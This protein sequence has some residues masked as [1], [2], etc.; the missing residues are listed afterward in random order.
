VA[1]SQGGFIGEDGNDLLLVSGFEGGWLQVTTLVYALDTTKTPFNWE[2]MDDIPMENVYTPWTTTSSGITHGGF[3]IVKDVYYMCGGYVGG[4]P[5]AATNACFKYNHTILPGGGEQWSRLPNLPEER[6]GGGMVYDSG[7]NALYFSAGAIRPNAGGT[8]TVDQPDTWMLDLDDVEDP[9]TV[10]EWKDLAPAKYTANH[11]G[12]VSAKDKAG[13]ERHFFYGGQDGHGEYDGNY[14]DLYEFLPSSNKWEAR[15]SMPFAR[16]HTSSSTVA[17]GCGFLIAGGAKNGGGK[18]SDVT[19]FDIDEDK[20][21]K[22][23]QLPDAINTPVCDI[24]GD[25]LYCQSG[26]IDGNFSVRRKIMIN[27]EASS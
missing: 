11:I 17:I 1:E 5:G 25:W 13:M 20:W 24:T 19:F 10:A 18:T 6:G 3:V 7:E 4:E 22:I 12:F 23:G 8:Y 2:P 16:G 9:N 27:K 21:T 26:H 15:Q 14:A